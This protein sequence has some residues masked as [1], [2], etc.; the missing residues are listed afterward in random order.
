MTFMNPR[1]LA[2][3][4]IYQVIEKNQSLSILTARELGRTSPRDRALV[5]ELCYGVLRWLPRLEFIIN[6]LMGNPLKGKQRRGHFLLMVGIYQQLYTRVPAHAAVSATVDAAHDL[7][8]ESLKKLI[9]GVLRSADRKQVELESAME[10]IPSFQYCHP[11]WILKR[12]KVAYPSRWQ[13]IA[14]QNN[15]RAPMWLRV[16][17]QQ[18]TTPDYLIE[19]S[20]V[21]IKAHLS[22]ST[23]T[24][25]RLDSPTSVESL[26]NFDQGIASVQDGAAQQA[27]ALLDPQPG[28][29]ILDACAAPGGKTC[30][31][32]ERQPQ[33][34]ELIAIDSDPTRLKRVDENL[35]R[36]GLK[37]TL[38]SADASSPDAWAKQLFDRILLDAPCSATGVIRRHPDIKWLRRE[39]DIAALVK[40]QA[41]ILQNL[42]P[43]LKP[44]GV[45]LYA[46]CSIL[47]DENST[48]ITHFLESNA[49]AELIPLHSG[50]SVLSPG[51]QILPGEE[52]MDGFY[53]AK[54]RKRT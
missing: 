16:N 1:A 52:S 7:R 24:A 41:Q 30:H 5:Q 31:I 12:L 29:V 9:N 18:S 17:Q 11:S 40:L 10:N 14:E 27:A 33:L 51:W 48:Q 54:L 45:M 25:L 3:D 13:T 28:E 44:G 38:I 53:Y 36:M 6:Q 42:W 22:A 15:G 20:K 34:A 8:L 2:A 26:P 4:I 21:S 46:T 50:D 49:N 39:T 43:W 23:P 19:L 37:A 35:K 32:L 47:P